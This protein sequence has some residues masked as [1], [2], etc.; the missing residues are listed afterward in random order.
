ME[1]L[2][3]DRFERAATAYGYQGVM[4]PLVLRRGAFSS[5]FSLE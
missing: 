2:L 1:L 3:P 4:K 5:P